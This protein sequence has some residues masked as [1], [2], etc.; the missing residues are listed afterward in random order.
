VAGRPRAQLAQLLLPPLLHPDA[1]RLSSALRG[2]A[3]AH[4]PSSTL[5]VSFHPFPTPSVSATWA[6]WP[7]PFV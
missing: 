3:F 6:A 1:T 7:W 2:L 4:T 5:S